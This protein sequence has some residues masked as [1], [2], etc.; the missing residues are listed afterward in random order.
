MIPDLSLSKDTGVT[1]R[2]VLSGMEDAT[3][4]L[5]EIFQG[6]SEISAGT[7]QLTQSVKSLT[8]LLHETQQSYTEKGAGLRNI[9]QELDSIVHISTG[10]G[11]P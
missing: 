1:I 8:E 11:Q 3:S 5:L 9:S 6:M 2:G 10:N 4:S 7:G